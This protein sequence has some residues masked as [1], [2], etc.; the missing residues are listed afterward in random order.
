LQHI[1]RK[2]EVHSIYKSVAEGV[3][4]TLL[5]LSITQRC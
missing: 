4:K 2:E 3:M 1:V 5:V